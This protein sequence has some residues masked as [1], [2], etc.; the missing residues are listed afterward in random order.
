MH[1]SAE[2]S[3]V[4]NSVPLCYIRML[5][6]LPN[7]AGFC[8]FETQFLIGES[9]AMHFMYHIEAY[10]WRCWHVCSS[11]AIIFDTCVKR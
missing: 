1:G 4:R 10:G 11:T 5:K 8:T 2:V 3:R 7:V 6:T 9:T